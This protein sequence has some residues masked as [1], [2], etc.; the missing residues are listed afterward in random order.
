MPDTSRMF[1]EHARL[2]PPGQASRGLLDAFA[3]QERMTTD[4]DFRYESVQDRQSIVKYLQAITAGIEQG[5]ISFGTHDHSLTL[6]PNG[7]LELQVR[8][9]RKGGRVKLGIKLYWREDQEEPGA[10]PLEIKV[11]S[12]SP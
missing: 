6:E 1:R 8:A 9:K 7:M 2:H 3:T 12:R 11:G 4:D 5:Q 10:D